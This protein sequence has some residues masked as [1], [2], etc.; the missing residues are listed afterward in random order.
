MDICEL[1][2]A[3]VLQELL[4]AVLSYIAWRLD[5]PARQHV[6]AIMA[7][8][9]SPQRSRDYQDGRRLRGQACVDGG[10]SDVRTGCWG[11]QHKPEPALCGN[12]YAGQ[13][14]VGPVRRRRVVVL[15]ISPLSCNGPT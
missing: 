6:S 12:R 5:D 3:G 14:H 4:C 15:L 7:R 1:R 9:A 11:Q 13:R 10:V 8:W 2:C